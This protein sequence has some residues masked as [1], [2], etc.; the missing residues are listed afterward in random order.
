[1]VDLAL[2]KLG[3]TPHL[4]MVAETIVCLPDAVQ[5]LT[6]CT[7]GNGFLQVLDWSPFPA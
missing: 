3:P 6:S 2:R 4:N 7:M 1:M 5:L